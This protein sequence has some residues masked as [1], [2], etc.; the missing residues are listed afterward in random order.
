MKK[1]RI[2]DKKKKRLMTLIIVSELIAACC[3]GAYAVHTARIYAKESAAA[4]A[5]EK[6]AEQ[7]AADKT[8]IKNIY[9]NSD[10]A[11]VR[12]AVQYVGNKGGKPFWSWYGYSYHVAWC[13]CFV[14][15][16]ADRTGHLSTD[17]PKFSFVPTG[18]SWFKSKGHF[19]Y[20][21][22]YTPESGDIIFFRAESS[23]TT[24]TSTSAGSHVG[25]VAGAYK[26][27]VYTI[28]G[29]HLDR[30]AERNYSLNSSLILGYGIV[31]ND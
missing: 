31:G 24:A 22:G 23:S 29:N 9:E 30:C 18:V 6:I 14:S 19:K 10:S 2:H 13:G 8:A 3:L 7:K 28:E 11:I 5:K 26:G 27:K 21:S 4:E 16:C 25:I 1:T 12:T 17:I 20:P 15:Y